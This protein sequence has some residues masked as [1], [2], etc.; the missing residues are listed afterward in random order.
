MIKQT[1]KGHRRP[2]PQIRLAVFRRLDELN[3]G[4]QRDSPEALERHNRRKA[5]LHEVFDHQ[6]GIKV[7]DWGATDDTQSHE[8]VEI[9]IGVAAAKGFEYVV[10]PGLKFLAQKLA[11]KA[12]DE[13]TS[14]AVKAIASWLRPKQ[15]E[16]KILD[17]IITLPDGTKIAVDP[18][19]RSATINIRLANGQIESTTTYATPPLAA[20]G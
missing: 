16:K 19:D 1:H 13:A 9:V 11:E 15:K 17:I 4:F 3:A 6:K 8:L 2:Q 7:L 12:V 20:T 14:E 18:P 5:A 10:V